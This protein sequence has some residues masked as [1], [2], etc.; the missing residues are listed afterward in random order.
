MLLHYKN[1][2]SKCI[3]FIMIGL[4]HLLC[5]GACGWKQRMHT[6]KKLL[7]SVISRIFLIRSQNVIKDYSVHIYREDFSHLMNLNVDHVSIKNISTVNR[8][9]ELSLPT[10]SLLCTLLS[11][12][13]NNYDSLLALLPLQVRCHQHIHY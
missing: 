7:G 4:A 11:S 2:P 8:I 10:G 3:F 13:V 1:N 6:S 12:S 9:T 5:P